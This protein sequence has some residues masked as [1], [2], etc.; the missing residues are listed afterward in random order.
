VKVFILA[1]QDDEIFFLPHILGSEKKLFIYLTNGV[2]RSATLKELNE[3][4]L[5]AKLVFQNLMACRNSIV[6]WWGLE[7]SISDGELHK[8]LGKDLVI[9]LS[10]VLLQQGVQ[11][12]K[13]FT[14][15]FE[16][17]HQDHDSAAAIARK[18][19]ES[20]QVELVEMSSYPQRFPNF[21][22]FRV[23]KPESPREVFKFNRLEVLLFAFRLMILYRT[24][25]ITWFGLGTSI[26][27]VYAFRK[28][29]SS[30]PLQIQI[31]NP[32]LYEFRGRAKQSDVLHYLLKI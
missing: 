22:S 32:C 14:T 31:L 15:S 27:G 21:Y 5:E 29:K 9:R 24:Q 7:N 8:H 16:G 30:N 18:L 19:A 26:F 6:V 2:P 10:E 4:T 1:H 3:R 17:A 25:S 28:Y 13:L 23:L 20:F 11:V 12:S